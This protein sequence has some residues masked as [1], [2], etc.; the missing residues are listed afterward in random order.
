[1]EPEADDD[2]DNKLRCW[3]CG[4][5]GIK[6]PCPFAEEMEGDDRPCANNCCMECRKECA[7]DV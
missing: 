1:M 7:N 6:G 2:N 5:E 3:Q 4:G